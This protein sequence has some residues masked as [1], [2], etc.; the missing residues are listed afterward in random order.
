MTITGLPY[1]TNDLNTRF[2][3]LLFEGEGKNMNFLGIANINLRT[4]LPYIRKSNG[5][6]EDGLFND[7]YD[8]TSFYIEVGPRKA[9]PGGFEALIDLVVCA[10][11][12]KFVADEENNIPAYSNEDIIDNVDKV[13]RLSQFEKTST[14]IDFEALAGFTYTEKI[15]ETMNPYFVFRVK[16]KLVGQLKID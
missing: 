10:N 13:M 11:M 1:Y 7:N 15:K 16:N 12:N 4:G 8:L 3:N 2:T 9:I 6:Y 5:D 14:L